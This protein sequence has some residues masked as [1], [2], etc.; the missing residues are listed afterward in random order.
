MFPLADTKDASAVRDVVQSIHAE[1]FPRADC[2]FVPRAF[3]WAMAAFAGRYRDYQ[4]IDA[5]YH[6]VEHTMQGTLCHA[7]ILKGRIRSGLKPIIPEKMFELGIIAIL[8]HDTGYLKVRGDD[9][10]TGAKYT[11]IH[12]SRSADFAKHLLLEK[13]F[14][15][16]DAACVARMIRC[17]GVNVKV[18]AIPFQTDAEKIIGYSLGTADL[19]GQMAASDYIDKLPILFDEFAESARYSGGEQ[20]KVGLFKNPE[21]LL[22][23]TGGFWSFYV[24]PK[25]D[26]D[27]GAQ[28]KFL[29]Q[30]YPDGQNDYL[31]HI[32]QNLERVKRIVAKLDGEVVRESVET[33]AE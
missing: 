9:E 15:P 26:G 17:T 10:G 13:G 22:R 33:S 1:L 11:L 28:Y 21:D 20:S 12:V 19:L 32:D 31:D 27:F 6:D 3:E 30:P 29:S 18:D 8:L 7:L 2:E 14:T 23:K 25:I 16:E 24:R 5:K 4:P